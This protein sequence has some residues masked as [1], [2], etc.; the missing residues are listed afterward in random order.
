MAYCEVKLEHDLNI[1]LVCAPIMKCKF[2]RHLLTRYIVITHFNIILTNFRIARG[3]THTYTGTYAFFFETVV[4][5]LL[6]V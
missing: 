6:K 4:P 5:E 2:L 1:I 3:P